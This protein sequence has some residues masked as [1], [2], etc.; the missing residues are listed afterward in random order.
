V[1]KQKADALPKTVR[2]RFT[3]LRYYRTEAAY[4]DAVLRRYRA[5]V[6]YTDTVLRRYR[7]E[8]A[9]TDTVFNRY[10]AET[11]YLLRCLF[12]NQLE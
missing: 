3:V 9:Y 12:V 7:A 2:I 10:S 6:A 8:V 11:L 1:Q 5:E 4:T